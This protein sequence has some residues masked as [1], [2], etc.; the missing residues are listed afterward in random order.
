MKSQV[1]P[2][3]TPAP[4]STE[5][6]TPTPPSAED[7]TP[8]P[9][10]AEEKEELEDEDEEVTHFSEGQLIPSVSGLSV[11]SYSDDSEISE[12]IIEEGT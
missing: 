3:A 10:N 12:D 5:D 8:A 1:S 11:H 4:P 2:D 6:V 7:V 9:P